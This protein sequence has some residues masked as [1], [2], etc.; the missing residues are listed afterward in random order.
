MMNMSMPT[1]WTTKSWATFTN[2]PPDVFPRVTVARPP[3]ADR[4]GTSQPTDFL[5]Q[6]SDMKRTDTNVASF[7][8]SLA[9]LP[10]ADDE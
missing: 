3:A 4:F 1:D 10:R 9:R 2:E 7:G 8:A 6:S 5:P